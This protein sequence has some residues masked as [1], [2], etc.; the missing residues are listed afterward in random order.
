MASN[1][2]PQD[3]L[4]A[5]PTEIYWNLYRPKPEPTEGPWTA[6]GEPPA[7]YLPPWPQFS[8]YD[9]GALDLGLQRAS[10][11]DTATNDIK[12]FEENYETWT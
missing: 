9:G 5:W 2:A 1:D 6:D 7:P 3:E 10:I 8:P 11:L 4:L 12:L